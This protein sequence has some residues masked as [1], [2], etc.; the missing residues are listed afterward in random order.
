M[1]TTYNFFK[2]FLPRLKD[3]GF[4]IFEVLIPHRRYAFIVFILICISISIFPPFLPL[5]KKKDKK[6]H[7][8]EHKNTNSKIELLRRDILVFAK[9]ILLSLWFH[10]CRLSSEYKKFFHSLFFLCSPK[11]SIPAGYCTCDS[12]SFRNFYSSLLLYR[13]IYR[14]IIWKPFTFCV[15]QWYTYLHR[16]AE[17]REINWWRKVRMAKGREYMSIL[18]RKKFG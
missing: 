16:G 11:K 4:C 9:K 3:L 2:P 8:G 5:P 6:S 15:M 18:T 7:A 1:R 13:Y 12:F 14:I 10:F 17:K